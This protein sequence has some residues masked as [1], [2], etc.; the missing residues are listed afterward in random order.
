MTSEESFVYLWFQ[1]AD[2]T[3]TPEASM[4][5]NIMNELFIVICTSYTQY[6]LS[7]PH[8]ISY[9]PAIFSQF[10]PI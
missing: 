4:P 10:T 8:A 7:M 9:A 6:L 5:N 3:T 2:A 1:M